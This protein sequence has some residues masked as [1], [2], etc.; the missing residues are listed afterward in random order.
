MSW[1]T[2]ETC[3]Q[4]AAGYQEA[5]AEVQAVFADAR[6][7]INE[8]AAADIG[9]LLRAFI[10][11]IGSYADVYFYRLRQLT[12]ELG[13][14]TGE[15]EAGKS[16]F[17]ADWSVD[18][19]VLQ[20]YC[21]EV[22]TDVFSRRSNDGVESTEILESCPNE[23]MDLSW[24]NTLAGFMR[25]P[26]RLP[27]RAYATDDATVYI[28]PFRYQVLSRDLDAMWVTASPRCLSRR[29]MS[30]ADLTVVDKFDRAVVVIQDRFDFRNFCHFL[31]DAVTRILH[32]VENF[33]YQDEFFVMGGIPGP[34][35]ELIA[36]ILCKVARIPATCLHFPD[37]GYL[38]KAVRKCVWFSDQK[39]I[40]THPAQMAHPRSLAALNQVAR[41]VPGTPS[42]AKRL[43][44]SR[45]DAGH[46]RIANEPELIKALEDRGFIAVQLAKI[47]VAE[48]V[49]LFRNAEVVVAPHGMGLTHIA[50]SNELGQ[51]IELF[52]PEAGTDAYAFVARSAGMHYDRVLG[53]GA[54]ATDKDFAVDVGQVLG[55]LGPEGASRPRPNWRKRAN[56]VPASKTFHG[57]EGGSFD[58]VPDWQEF[59]FTPMTSDQAVR[60][61]CKSEPAANTLVGQWT[62]IDVAPHTL[63]VA[64]CWVWTPKHLPANEVSLRIPGWNI[65]QLQ[66]ANLAAARTWQRISCTALSPEN[67]SRCEVG[68]HVVGHQ[69]ATLASTCWQMERG[70][71]PSAYTATG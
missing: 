36:G 59:E 54:H 30:G 2:A 20:R 26:R 11:G 24:P 63:Y 9:K 66:T 1:W 34:Y 19:D 14:R 48:Q 43:Y 64:S 12:D 56:L 45:G 23:C 6:A 69:G 55:L 17:N 21:P 42:T 40:H 32:Y 7:M 5:A 25:R 51:V 52:H 71:A 33:G 8:S 61:H 18:A 68:L 62:N 46:R 28:H 22:L 67:C 10:S 38:F 16:F 39:E 65:K 31:F 70:H 29:V 58:P 57:F 13:Q 3:A 15:L 27:F 60:F 44:I 35:Q 53:Q 47:R 41:L 50:M 37:R 49:G 4:V